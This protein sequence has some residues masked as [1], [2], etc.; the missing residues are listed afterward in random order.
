[1]DH[2]S[3]D[4]NTQI[5]HDQATALYRACQSVL[6]HRDCLCDS[7]FRNCSVCQCRSAVEAIHNSSIP[8]D[9]EL[10]VTPEQF[11]E[12]FRSDDFHQQMSDDECRE[13]FAYALKGSS[14][15]TAGFL[16]GILSDYCVENLIVVN[17]DTLDGK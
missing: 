5:T 14:D 9:T 7:D 6:E 13:L 4:P 17:T 15:F 12:F 11:M 16:N 1:M 2:S 3:E 8:I 10:E